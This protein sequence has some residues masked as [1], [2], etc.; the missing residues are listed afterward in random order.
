MSS[1]FFKIC[2]LN[3]LRINKWKVFFFFE[4]LHRGKRYFSLEAA[5]RSSLIRVY[6]IYIILDKSFSSYSS[7]V[8]TQMDLP[9]VPD[10]S[11]Q[12]ANFLGAVNSVAPFITVNEQSESN[13]YHFF[14]SRR[15]EFIITQGFS[16]T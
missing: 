9:Q 4:V 15:S 8:N 3:G 14:A 16:E 11:F 1:G 10:E 5:Y 2:H 12:N 7:L 13:H 6:Y